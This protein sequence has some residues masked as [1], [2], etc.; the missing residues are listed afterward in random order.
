MLIFNILGGEFID[1]IEWIDD[2]CDIMVYCFLIVGSVIKYGVKLIV[3]EG[4]VVVFIYE[5]QF[6]DVFGFGF[7]MLEIN[8][9]LILMCLQYWDYGFCFLFKFEIYFVNIICFNDLKWGMKNLV[10][11]CDL[12]FGVV[13]LCV[14]G[15]YL[16]CVIDLGKFMLEIVG[17]DGEFIK[18]EISFQLC[19]IIVQ[20]FFCMIVGLGILVLDM[21]V[22]IGQFGSMIVKV[23]SLIVM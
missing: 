7:Y 15:I 3:C 18:D 1:I 10:I 6:V 19:N 16:M 20:E 17:M 14:F 4:Q 23:I 9:L 8:N 13:W 2:I 22:N 21:V 12:E 11:V 5:G